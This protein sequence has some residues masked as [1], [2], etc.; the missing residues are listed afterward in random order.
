MV[1]EFCHRVRRFKCAMKLSSCAQMRR[2]SLRR[3]MAAGHTINSFRMTLHYFTP[4]LLVRWQALWPGLQI[5]TQSIA[6]RG[7]VADGIE[8]WETAEA[9]GPPDKDNIL[10]PPRVACMMRALNASEWCFCEHQSFESCSNRQQTF[11]GKA[12][13]EHAH[14]RMSQF[15][16]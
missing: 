16:G 13:N 6:R 4:V 10:V 8:V 7:G 9:D 2:I 12:E 11:E 14:W 1:S 15:L 3:D 5:A